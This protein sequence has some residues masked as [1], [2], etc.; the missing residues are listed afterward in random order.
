MLQQ[1]RPRQKSLNGES[2]KFQHVTTRYINS[3][4]KVRICFTF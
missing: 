3:L 1:V 4:Y 2:T